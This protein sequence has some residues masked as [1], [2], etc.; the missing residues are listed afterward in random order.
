MAI[1]AAVGRFRPLLPG[2]RVC[3][4]KLYQAANTPKAA[5]GFRSF[6]EKQYVIQF[7]RFKK[8]RCVP[9]SRSTW[10]AHI[11]RACQPSMPLM[12]VNSVRKTIA[13]P[14]TITSRTLMAWK[15]HADAPL[16]RWA[17]YFPSVS[18]YA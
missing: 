3:Q 11:V 1:M 13:L 2:F 8:T 17:K 14:G 16:S 10:L 7:S 4:Q 15:K 18:S 12:P 9:F 5:S 6:F